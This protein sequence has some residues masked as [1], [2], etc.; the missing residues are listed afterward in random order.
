MSAVKFNEYFQRLQIVQ[1]AFDDAGSKEKKEV[2][3]KIS[4]CPLPLKKSLRNY[5]DLLLFFMG[6]PEEKEI[7][8][9]A[10]QELQR[11]T[12]FLRESPEPAK[13]TNLKNTGLPFTTIEA[14]FGFD[15]VCWLVERFPLEISLLSIDT[16]AEQCDEIFS[17]LLPEAIRNE[18]DNRKILS[19]SQQLLKFAG[20]N[21]QQHLPWLINLF[22]NAVLTS[23]VKTYLFSELIVYIRF[24]IGEDFFMMLD[25]SVCQGKIFYHEEGLFKKPELLK[26]LSHKKLNEFKL[27]ITAKEELVERSKATLFTLLRET[28]P[29]TKAWIPAT[30]LFD[31]GRGLYAGLF[32][33]DHASRLSIESYIG[34]L[35]YKNSVPI[36]YGGAWITGNHARIGVNIFPWFRGGESALTFLQIIRL[37]HQS[38]G[39]L[40][41]SVEPYQ[42]GKNNS[43]GIKSGA[44]WFYYK[45]GFRPEQPI[46][47]KIA[48]DETLKM[49]KQKGYRSSSKT[50]QQL[51]DSIMVLRINQ[52]TDS[53]LDSSSISLT[54]ISFVKEKFNGD[55]AKAEQQ[56]SK[57]LMMLLKISKKDIAD[58]GVR[59]GFRKLSIFLGAITQFELTTAR[60]KSVIR[61]LL[62]AKGMSHERDFIETWIGSDL[63]NKLVI[64]AISEQ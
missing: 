17:M 2:L 15:L 54:M 21:K 57:R 14:S 50:L 45:L 47:K 28:D 26:I 38:F 41:F 24:R 35:A 48:A 33:L 51:A 32:T 9:L 22:R 12:A 6:Y 25:E 60:Q 8:L 16:S 56:C 31:L 5:Y 55:Y 59:N 49:A 44:F 42:I 18:R 34:Y 19:T 27:S 1:Q 20:K 7:Y 52:N 58:E 29:V 39:V 13:N 36:T 46:L 43:D 62:L 4:S 30:E 23:E 61:K 11:V 63:W 10:Q 64:N 3:R 37:Y 53:L 40:S